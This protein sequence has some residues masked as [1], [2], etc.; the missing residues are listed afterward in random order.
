MGRTGIPYESGGGRPKVTVGAIGSNPRSSVLINCHPPSCTSQWCRWQSRIRL[1]NSV[2]PPLIQWTRWC[3]SH[4]EAGRSQPAHWQ[5]PSRALSARRAGP[6]MTRLERPTSTT[7]D[8]W[9]RRTRVSLLK[10]IALGVHRVAV[11]H[12]LVVEL[13]GRHLSCQIEQDQLIEAF[14][15]S[16]RG[17]RDHGQVCKP[18]LP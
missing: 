4:R 6:E 2:F 12:A 7:T 9:S 13:A 14:A 15:E 16:N 1:D 10:G 3:P 18:D 8:R 17:S 11:L 5:W